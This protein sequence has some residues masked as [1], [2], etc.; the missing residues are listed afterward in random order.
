MF[1]RLEPFGLFCVSYQTHVHVWTH[2]DSR[3][4]LPPGPYERPEHI[5]DIHTWGASLYWKSDM[6]L[7][8][9]S[10]TQTLVKQELGRS[11][12]DPSGRC[13]GADEALFNPSPVTPPQNKVTEPVCR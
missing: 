12:V 5:A 1:P 7:K 10:H 9:H 4:I 13:Q 2:T 3:V 6:H 8:T 11:R